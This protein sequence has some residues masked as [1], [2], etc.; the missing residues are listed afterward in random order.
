MIIERKIAENIEKILDKEPKIILLY[1]PRQAGKTTL[2]N[3]ILSKVNEQEVAF[4]NGDDLRTQ[5]ALSVANLDSLKKII[6]SK[7]FLIIDEAQRIS[8]IG[9]TLKL[10]FDSLGIK[11]IASGSSSFEIAGKVNEPLT[12]RATIF[13]LYPIALGEI[14]PNL[15]DLSLQNRLEDF[16]LFG[17]Y[18]KVLTTEG[19]QDKQKYLDDLVNS[20]LYKDI[21]SFASVRKPKK[22]IDLLSLLALQIG[23]EVSIAELASHLALSK[24]AVEKYLDILEKMFV[25]FNLRGFSR[26]LRKEIYKTSKYYFW[27]LGLRNV[28]IRNFNPLNLRNDKGAMLENFFLMEK[29]KQSNNTDKFANFYF[30]RTYDQKEIDFIEEKDDNLYAYEIKWGEKEV[31]PP[32]DWV[33]NYPKSQFSVITSENLTSFFEEK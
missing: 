13:Y 23:S 27:D 25:I 9:L 2:L 20:Y 17:M 33:A 12:G 10:L 11:I 19:S 29:I 18:P 6:G 1:G 22:V 28:L 30:W 21:L 26:N 8:N 31:K 32:K 14:M 16:L 7:K 3:L 4:L 24:Q 5:E 15:P